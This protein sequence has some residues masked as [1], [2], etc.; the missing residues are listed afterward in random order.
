MVKSIVRVARGVTNQTRRTFI[1]VAI[2]AAMVLVRF[3]IDVASG[4]GK[5]GKIG[6][7]L[8]AFRTFHPLPLVFSAVNREILGVVLCV[9]RRGPTRVCGVAT[10]AIV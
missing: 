2:D 3:R 1:C 8:V 9:L 6:R 5:F 4:T 10:G 7:V